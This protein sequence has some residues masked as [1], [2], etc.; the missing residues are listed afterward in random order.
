MSITKRMN[1]A[2]MAPEIKKIYELIGITGISVTHFATL[3]GVTKQAMYYWLRGHKQPSEPSLQKLLV[4]YKIVDSFH[5]QGLLPAPSETF[6]A[7]VAAVLKT[8]SA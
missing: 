6:K 8:K 5:K 2:D 3:A 7:M 1:K 4:A